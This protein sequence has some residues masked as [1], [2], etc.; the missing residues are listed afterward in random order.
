MGACLSSPYLLPVVLPVRHVFRS[1]ATNL[2]KE[3]PLKFSGEIHHRQCGGLN[4]VG[5]S[6]AA[7]L[8]S[9]VWLLVPP[10]CGSAET[11]PPSWRACM[12][13]RVCQLCTG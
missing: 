13:V 5:A 6:R 10:S 12:R 7:Y 8:A 11:F 1:F 9:M 2:S 4:F 3:V